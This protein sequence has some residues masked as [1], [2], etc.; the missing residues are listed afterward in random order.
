MEYWMKLIVG[1]LCAILLAG[2]SAQT[3]VFA[4]SM[5]AAAGQADKQ[6]YIVILKDP[7]LAA[8]D[9]RILMTPERDADSTRLPATANAFTGAKK[10]DVRSPRSRQYLQFL[11]E[12]FNHFRGS[13]IL[14]LGRQ[15]KTIHR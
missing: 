4:K 5:G 3:P 13:A 12:R 11:D 10:L 14:E 7:P 8:Y 15:L 2:L 1:M 9:G 6:R